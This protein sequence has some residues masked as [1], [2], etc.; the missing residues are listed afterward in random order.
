M[1]NR[2][3]ILAVIAIVLICIV[4]LVI[5]AYFVTKGAGEDI[6]PAMTS[7]PEAIVTPTP[8]PT[9]TPEETIAPTP[10]LKSATDEPDIENEDESA[11]D[12][13][14][15]GEISFNGVNISQFFSEPVDALGS[16]LSQDPEELELFYKDFSIVGTRYVDDPKN[17]VYMITIPDSNMI[18]INDI[19]INKQRDELVSLFGNPYSV[20]EEGGVE[21]LFYYVETPAAEKY[22]VSFIFVNPGSNEA[23]QIL[24]GDALYG[25]S[26]N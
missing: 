10:E 1:K 7:T 20:T 25:V 15:S 18:E 6:E 24:I 11:I 23:P 17:M 13:I 14:I 4:L 22:Q 21:I 16:P 9:L 5:G 8:K 3:N 26:G 19:S 2:K 12:G